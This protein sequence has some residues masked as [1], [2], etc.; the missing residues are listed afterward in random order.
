MAQLY[1]RAIIQAMRKYI[2]AQSDALQE[3]IISRATLAIDK[4][5]A[6]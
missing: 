3:F 6:V 4:Y 2:H 1:T 5:A